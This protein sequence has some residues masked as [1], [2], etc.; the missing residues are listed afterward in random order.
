MRKMQQQ[1]REQVN[2]EAHEAVSN[3]FTDAGQHA[4]AAEAASAAAA[5]AVIA[6]DEVTYLRAGVDVV[7]LNGREVT[8]ATEGKCRL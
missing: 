1:I 6:A 8:E 2:G 4:M 5:V 3:F 7:T